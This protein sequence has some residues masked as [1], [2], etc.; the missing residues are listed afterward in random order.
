MDY[1]YLLGLFLLVLTACSKNSNAAPEAD[2]IDEAM[3]NPTAPCYLIY[4]PVCGCDGETYSN[5]CLATNN[6]V[7]SFE[8]GACN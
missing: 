6:G 1:K 8:E 5:D 3:I 4:A 2:C 7:L